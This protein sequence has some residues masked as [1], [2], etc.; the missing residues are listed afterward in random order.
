MPESPATPSSRPDRRPGPCPLDSTCRPPHKAAIAINSGGRVDGPLNPLGLTRVKPSDWI[1]SLSNTEHCA[2]RPGRILRCYVRRSAIHLAGPVDSMI[3][4]PLRPTR[5]SRSG[6]EKP[7][8]GARKPPALLGTSRLRARVAA[9]AG[10]GQS[11]RLTWPSAAVG[12]PGRGGRT[13]GA[14]LAGGE[15][16]ARPRFRAASGLSNSKHRWPIL[17]PRCAR[18]ITD[19]NMPLV[20]ADVPAARTRPGSAGNHLRS[21]RVCVLEGLLRTLLAGLECFSL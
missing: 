19:S 6:P 1:S 10:P 13:P 11:Q 2:Y 4:G 15:T 21:V 14:G 9:V 3:A 16:W 8:R 7:D 20:P 18:Q 12:R 5:A 17:R